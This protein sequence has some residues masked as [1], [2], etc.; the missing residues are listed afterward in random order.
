MTMRYQIFN[1]STSW[2]CCFE[3]S[4]VDTKSIEPSLAGIKDSNG[5]YYYKTMCECFNEVEAKEICDALNR[6]QP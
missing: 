6:C 1:Y 4:V 3:F 2:H 5:N